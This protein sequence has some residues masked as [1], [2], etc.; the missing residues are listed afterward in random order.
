MNENINIPEN[1]QLWHDLRSVCSLDANKEFVEIINVE[2]K[3]ANQPELTTEEFNSF[4]EYA[5]AH[6]AAIY[7]DIKEATGMRR[8]NVPIKF[9]EDDKRVVTLTNKILDLEKQIKELK[10]ENEAL[11]AGLLV[12]S[13][14]F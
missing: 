9:T 14:A 1:I 4:L 2:R 8:Q 6:I 11:K 5:E 7:A 13:K 3:H 10:T 12:Q